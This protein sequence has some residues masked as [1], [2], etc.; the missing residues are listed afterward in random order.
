MKVILFL[1]FF[2]AL[3]CLFVI[4]YVGPL[5]ALILIGVILAGGFVDIFGGR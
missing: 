3:P 4:P 5:L 1:V 2:M